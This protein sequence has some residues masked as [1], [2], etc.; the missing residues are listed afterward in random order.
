MTPSLADFHMYNS[1][2]LS[3]SVVYLYF[4]LLSINELSEAS[5]TIKTTG[6]LEVNW[7]DSFLQWDPNNY[8]GVQ[9]Y[10]FQQVHSIECTR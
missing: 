3:V 7:N 4:F 1:C 9:S 2:C 6:Y 8:G 10:Q 5:A